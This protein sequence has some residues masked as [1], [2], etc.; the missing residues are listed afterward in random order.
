MSDASAENPSLLDNLRKS[1]KEQLKSENAPAPD[2]E[3]AIKELKVRKKALENKE[4]ELA[5][6][7]EKF[8]RSKMEDLLKRRFFLSLPL[9]YME[10]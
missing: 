2:V 5:P 1:V 8:D 4:K 6:K 9:K 10:V 7:Q 3:V